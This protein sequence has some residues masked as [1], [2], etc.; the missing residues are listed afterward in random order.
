MEFYKEYFKDKD[1][2][3]INNSLNMLNDYADMLSER[4]GDIS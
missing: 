1:S 2:E 3:I 4:K